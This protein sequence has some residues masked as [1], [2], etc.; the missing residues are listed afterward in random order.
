MY[1]Y[2]TR[3]VMDNVVPLKLGN[4]VEKRNGQSWIN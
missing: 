4:P 3:G 2:K 1:T